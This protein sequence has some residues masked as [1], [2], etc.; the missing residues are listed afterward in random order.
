MIE[1]L[2]WAIAL[3]ATSCVATFLLA[4]LF[5]I[6]EVANDWEKAWT[7][8]IQIVFWVWVLGGLGF[9]L[10]ALWSWVGVA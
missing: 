6:A 5:K 10:Y 7:Y 4:G 1:I 8:A 3:I 9:G 2:K